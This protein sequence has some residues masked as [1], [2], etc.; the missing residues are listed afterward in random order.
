MSVFQGAHARSGVLP[1]TRS[2]APRRRNARAAS[3]AGS[4]VPIASAGSASATASATSRVRPTGL[5]MVAI[6][7]A[8]MLGMV[9]LTQTLGAS[10]TSSKV[11]SLQSQGADLEAEISRNYFQVNPWTDE[12]KVRTEARRL[13]LRDLVKPTLVLRAP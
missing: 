11:Y 6:M 13:K 7:A 10:A 4:A 12:D 5:L 9:Y 8:T 1:R 2:A 3:G